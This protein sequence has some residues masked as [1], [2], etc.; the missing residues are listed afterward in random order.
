MLTV[1]ASI[2]LRRASRV[3][4]FGAGAV[5]GVLPLVAYNWWAF[6]S[7]FHLSYESRDLD[8]GVNAPSFSLLVQLLFSHWGLLQISPV[9]VFGWVGA[10]LLYRS[11]RPEALVCA[12]IPML[13]LAFN[14]TL[15]H[16]PWGGMTGPR[17]V[18][19]ALPFL[20]LPLAVTYS[21]YPLSTLALAIPSLCILVALAATNPVAGWDGHLLTRLGSSDGSAETVADMVG[22]TGWYDIVPF[23]A[24]I[25]FSATCA[26][27]ATPFRVQARELPLAAATALGWAVVAL[28]GP[29]LLVSD[30]MRP[31]VSASIVLVLAVAVAAAVATQGPRAI[32]RRA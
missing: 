28:V 10:L 11:R 22:I 7:A 29:Q 5:V 17:Y 23:Y 20:A 27:K 12:V 26:V 31:P 2:G 13:Y 1:Y 6:G 18:I 3:V 19:A 32:A 21:R 9:L 25:A 24:A 16:W 14:A 30:R 15:T 4:S 8:E